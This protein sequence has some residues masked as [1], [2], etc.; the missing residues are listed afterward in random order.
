VIFNAEN[1]EH[2]ENGKNGER[3]KNGFEKGFFLCGLCALCVE[4]MP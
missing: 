4:I 1:A 2:A 3:L